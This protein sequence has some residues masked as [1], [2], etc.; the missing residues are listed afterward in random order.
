MSLLH[1]WISIEPE[2][3]TGILTIRDNEVNVGVVKNIGPGYRADN[4]DF[5]P[6]E[7]IKVGDKILFTQ[8]LTYEI[9]G[10]KVYRLRYRDVIE[11]LDVK[12]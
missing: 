5:I 6:T 7:G 9:D 4:G 10:L 12:V 2:V 8:H 3:G 11:V 1:D